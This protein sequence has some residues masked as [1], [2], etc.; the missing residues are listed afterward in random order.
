MKLI[1]LNKFKK[2]Q[3]VELDGCTYEVRTLTVDEFLTQNLQQE[4]EEAGDTKGQVVKM[5]E[6][7]C[8]FT[9][10]PEEILRQQP[11]PVLHALILLT[12]GVDPESKA[13]DEATDT[14]KN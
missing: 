12:Q 6:L 9:T 5:I 7:L 1:N 2:N 4:I 14:A 10:I 3:E 8:R 11:F 13:Q